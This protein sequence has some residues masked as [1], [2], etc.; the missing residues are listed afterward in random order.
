MG[1]NDGFVRKKQDAD[2]NFSVSCKKVSFFGLLVHVGVTK[3]YW[4]EE[5]LK[6]MKKRQVVL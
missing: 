2:L 5:T 4:Q 1:K 6:L 3:V